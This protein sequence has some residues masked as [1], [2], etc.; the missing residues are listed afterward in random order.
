[1]SFIHWQIV[2]DKRSKS[3]IFKTLG[4]PYDHM[5]VTLEI[6][7]LR[8]KQGLGDRDCDYSLHLE[9]HMRDHYALCSK[10]RADV[11][12]NMAEL[13]CGTLSQ[14]ALSVV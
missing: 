6:W 2:F 12:R 7:S 3:R 13:I 5:P 10:K 8:L 1:M 9:G 11:G 4:D 14:T